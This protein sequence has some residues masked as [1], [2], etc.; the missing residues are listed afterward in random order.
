[1]LNARLKP[2]AKNPPKGATSEAKH[3]MK[4]RWNIYVV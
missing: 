2:E 3:D 4:R 1:M